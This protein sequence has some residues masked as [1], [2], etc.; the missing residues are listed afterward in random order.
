[1]SIA[2]SVALVTGASRGLGG[3]LVRALREAGARRVY[4]AARSPAAIAGGDGVVTPCRLDVTDAASVAA[5]ARF[6]H[7]VT[8]VFNN[9]GSMARGALLADRDDAARQD[10]ETNFFGALNVLRA[11]SGVIV[12]NGGGAFV[13]IL[14]VSALANSPDAGGYSASK[15][16]AHSMT[17]AARAELAPRG[18]AVFGAYPGPLD[19]E[20]ATGLIARKA[21]PDMVARAILAGVASGQDDIWPDDM[22]RQ[23]AAVWSRSPKLLERQF[24][25]LAGRAAA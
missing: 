17:Q 15:A 11:F 19:T 14:S 20:M 18:I 16:A 10:M 24:A 4:A 21:A 2:N 22:A 23:V 3:A 7:D 13:N 6:A 1:M 9:A 25:N 8:L 5:A 12:R